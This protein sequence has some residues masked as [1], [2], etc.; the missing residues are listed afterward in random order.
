MTHITIGSETYLFLR[1]SSNLICGTIAKMY[2]ILVS[3]EHYLGIDCECRGINLQEPSSG[4]DI[5]YTHAH[6]INYAQSI[7]YAHTV[8]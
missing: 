6:L 7:N 3:I 1:M 8:P 4:T 5:S 2:T